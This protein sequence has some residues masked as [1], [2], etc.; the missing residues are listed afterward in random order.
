LRD[1]NYGDDT[2]QG[3]SFRSLDALLR[4]RYIDPDYVGDFPYFKVRLLQAAVESSAKTVGL[5]VI[6]GAKPLDD[7]RSSKI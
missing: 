5:A 6:I 2:N 7:W 1:C 4:V 3:T